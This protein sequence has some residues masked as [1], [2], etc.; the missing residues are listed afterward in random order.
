M[1]VAMT[2]FSRRVFAAV[3]IVIAVAAVI[4]SIQILLLAFAGILLALFFRSSGMWL[5]RLTGLS[6]KWSMALTLL[7]FA[8]LAFSALWLFGLQIVNQA[9]QLSWAVSQAYSQFH[10]KLVQYHVASNNP[11]TSGLSLE[12]PAKEAASSV[13]WMVAGGVLILFLGIY[14]SV[15]PELYTELFLSF[16]RRPIRV[17]AAELLDSIGTALRWWLAGQLIS[18]AV[19]GAITIAGLSIVGAP[20]PVS[21]GVLAM[22]LTFVPYIGAIASAVPAV[23][24]AF[25]IDSRQTLSVM[26][27]YLIAH[28]VE[29]YIVTPL[30]QHR[31]VY[32]PPALILATQF[33]CTSLPEP[34]E[35]CWP[36]H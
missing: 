33:L 10:E 27:V 23:L 18:M 31:L 14:L 9:H 22:I 6:I 7:V 26:L 30:I 13:L 3:L 19:V 20:M 4:Y 21:L 8:T 11:A 1:T 5:Q 36:L 29:G 35:S 16:F 12:S 15:T 32:L 28:I 17:R 34:S 25:T 24:L 2:Q